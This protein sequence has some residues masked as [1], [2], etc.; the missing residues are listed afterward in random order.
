MSKQEIV[1]TFF[2]YLHIMFMIWMIVHN[3]VKIYLSQSKL[4]Y[5]SYQIFYTPLKS[6]YSSESERWRYHLKRQTSV[7]CLNSLLTTWLKLGRWFIPYTLI[8]NISISIK[9]I[10]KSNFHQSNHSL[11][12]QPLS[13]SSLILYIAEFGYGGKMVSFEEFYYI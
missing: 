4:F 6:V 2:N 5:G 9:S 10:F 3:L 1:P 12:F 13:L 7:S 8:N 11:I